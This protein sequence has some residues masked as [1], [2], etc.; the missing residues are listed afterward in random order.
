MSLKLIK[1]KNI[2]LI[3]FK[4]RKIQLS[5]YPASSLYHLRKIL[6]SESYPGP[7]CYLE[8]LL[9][10]PQNVFSNPLQD[11]YFTLLV[12]SDLQHLSRLPLNL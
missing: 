12:S 5:A 7:Q 8:N 9:Y 4:N 3:A 6:T 1:N 11:N 10:F 2:I